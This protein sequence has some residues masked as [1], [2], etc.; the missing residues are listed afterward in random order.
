MRSASATDEPPNFCTTRGLGMPGILLPR[1][2]DPHH[3]TDGTMV[4][5][6][7]FDI[8]SLPPI[9]PIAGAALDGRR[10]E[11]EAADGNRF[12]AYRA[13]PTTRTGS[14]VVIL[15]DVRGLHPFY[16]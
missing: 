14:G 5:D 10:V 2:A 1:F 6:M 7:C 11:S 8:D 3:A 4:A 12:A 16:E 15:P 9:P 13:R